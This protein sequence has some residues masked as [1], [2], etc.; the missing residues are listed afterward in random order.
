[1]S[2]RR[3][4]ARGTMT[5]RRGRKKPPE[6]DHVRSRIV[7]FISKEAGDQE[8][9]ADVKTIGLWDAVRSEHF[10]DRIEAGARSGA[11]GYWYSRLS[12]YRPELV[13]RYADAVRQAGFSLPA[14]PEPIQ[15]LRPALN[16]FLLS[17]EALEETKTLFDPAPPGSF[18]ANLAELSPPPEPKQLA[19]LIANGYWSR[20]RP[21]ELKP[22]LE[23]ALHIGQ[24]A[25]E[26]L[27]GW[28]RF[29]RLDLMPAVRQAAI[30]LDAA[31]SPKV[32]G[33]EAELE[34]V[35][36][37]WASLAPKLTASTL[38]KLLKTA[39]ARSVVATVI[40]RVHRH[41]PDLI[42]VIE[43]WRARNQDQ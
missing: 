42:S 40:E 9:L 43:K 29:Y 27:V 10:A 20:I 24:D 12:Y 2:P 1:M 34:L 18:L 38:R 35:D 19:Y 33:E 23:R 30:E 22:T 6:A 5:E 17:P 32:I 14:K 16:A 7:E 21:E 13:P 15:W 25:V 39:K 41:R 26:W 3:A 11:L 28:L 37:E 8:S 4:T 36:S 31:Q